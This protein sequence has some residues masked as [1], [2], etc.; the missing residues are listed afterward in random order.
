MNR[1]SA[2]SGIA[3]GENH[4]RAV[5]IVRHLI[6]TVNPNG[7][8]V[9]AVRSTGRRPVSL[10]QRAGG[11]VLRVR[12]ILSVKKVVGGITLL[13]LVLLIVVLFQKGA[14]ILPGLIRLL[15]GALLTVREKNLV[16]LHFPVH[17]EGVE[18]V[19]VPIADAK[20]DRACRN[21]QCHRH[22]SDDLHPF[23]VHRLAVSF[24]F[25]ISCAICHRAS[26]SIGFVRCPFMPFSRER[27][28]S[29]T[30]ASADRA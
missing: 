9:C 20:L 30:K 23:P 18:A 25:S 24:L 21:G 13:G 14:V 17:P 11:T 5:G 27:R 28:S 26:K 15:A 19:S 8:A 29:S 3:A 4:V 6:Y 16:V 2:V 12:G 10:R 7:A 22:R 1:H